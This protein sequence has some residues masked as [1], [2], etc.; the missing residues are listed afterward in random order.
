MF[1]KHD[2][3]KEFGKSNVV[4]FPIMI[5]SKLDKIKSQETFEHTNW[6]PNKF[7]STS[8]L[9]RSLFDIEMEKKIANRYS[10]R[11]MMSPDEI[12]N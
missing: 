12:S 4:I 8:S 9:E 5:I 11:I 6:D 1:I 2:S 10:T 3:W 7:L